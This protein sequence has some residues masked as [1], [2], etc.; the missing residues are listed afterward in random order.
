MAAKFLTVRCD[1]PGATAS[2]HEH[3]GR[4]VE[5]AATSW[6]LSGSRLRGFDDALGRVHSPALDPSRWPLEGDWPSPPQLALSATVPGADVLVAEPRTT[7]GPSTSLPFVVT[8]RGPEA[9]WS[10]RYLPGRV[11]ATPDAVLCADGTLLDAATPAAR[12]LGQLPKG[13][14]LAAD[15]HG[16]RRTKTGLELLGRVTDPLTTLGE[17]ERTAPAPLEGL[18]IRRDGAWSRCPEL[19]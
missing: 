11:L 2:Q 17:L 19:A 4:P 5:L 14:E 16:Y 12:L 13:L 9:T 18:I 1:Q 3:L 15:G 8:P 10:T 7:P 6:I